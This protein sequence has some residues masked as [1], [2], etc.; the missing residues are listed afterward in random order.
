MGQGGHMTDERTEAIQAVVD[1]ITSYQ[2]SAP[3]G[4]V[5]KELREALDETDLELSDEEVSKIVD[6]VEKS[7]ERVDVAGLL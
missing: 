2:A 6:A 5:E 7:E 3:E 4:T 1:R